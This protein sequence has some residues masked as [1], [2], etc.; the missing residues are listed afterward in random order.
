[1]NCKT[2]RVFIVSLLFAQQLSMARAQNPAVKPSRETRLIVDDGRYVED[3]FTRQVAVTND[4]NFVLVSDF[5]NGVRTFDASTGALVNS[6]E[7][8]SLPGDIRYDPTHQLFLTSGDVKIKIWDWQQQT[9]VKLVQQPVPSQFMKNLYVDTNKQYLFANNL[10]YSYATGK[11]VPAQ[12]TGNVSGRWNGPDPPPA[13]FSGDRYYIFD[14]RTG[15]VRIYNCLN[16]NL[17]RSYVLYHYKKGINNY[18]DHDSSYLFIS[19]LDGV[20]MISLSDGRSD[21]ASFDRTGAYD[22][23][24]E[25]SC[26]A[27]SFDGTYLV[28]GSNQGA[29][30]VILKKKDPKKGFAGNTAEVY[31]E[32]V[33]V[34]E[35]HAFHHSNKAVYTT[36]EAIH[37]LDLDEQSV[38]WDTEPK[39]ISARNI[40]FAP[41]GDQLYFAIGRDPKVN[42][43]WFERTY[44]EGKFSYNFNDYF[45]D[46]DANWGVFREDLCGKQLFAELVPLWEDRARVV[47]FR[48]HRPLA[49]SPASGE[50]PPT[51]IHGTSSTTNEP[52]Q[53]GSQPTMVYSPSR[54][55]SV[56]IKDFGQSALFKDGQRIGAVSSSDGV[57]Y[58]IEW[59]R[60][61]QYMAFGGSGRW[62]TVVNMG[63]GQPAQ[64]VYGESYI[65]T[66]AFSPDNKFLFTGSLKNEILMWRLSDG[67]LLRRLSGSNGGI[68]DTA[69]TPDGKILVSTAGDSSLRFWELPTGKLLISV[70]LLNSSALARELRRGIATVVDE[71]VATC[72]SPLDWVAVTPDGRFDSNNLE[73]TR[74]LHWLKSDAALRP[75]P[76]EIFTRDYYEPGL[77]EKVLN[78]T[79]LKPLRSLANLDTNIPLIE[80]TNV[81]E[82]KHSSSSDPDASDHGPSVAVTV[83]VQD[84]RSGSQQ[85]GGQNSGSYDLRLFRDGQLVG[86]WPAASANQLEESSLPADAA[87]QNWRN[88]HALKV[89]SSGKAVITFDN[90][91]LP[92]RKGV[93]SVQF[94]AYA[95]NS[96]RVKSLTTT[97]FIYTLP[98]PKAPRPLRRAYLVTMGV[99]ANQSHNLALELAVSSAERSRAVL[100]NKLNVDYQDVVEIPLYSDFAPDSNEVRIDT[101]RKADLHAVLDLLAGRT[102]DATIR[103][104]VDPKGQLRAA[105]PDDAVILYVASHGYADPEGT[106]YLLPSDT[107]ANW[108]ITEDVLTRCH[109]QPDE[110]AVCKHANDLL[111]H[112]VSSTELGAWWNGVDGGEMV[113]ILDSCHSGAVSGKEFRPG[114]LGDPG[115]GQSSYDKGMQIL[116]ASQPAQTAKGEWV[117][118]KGGGTIL[119]DALET[120][121]Q[122]KPND[123]LT[124]WLHDIEVQLP[125]TAKELYPELKEEDAQ[126]PV[127]LD[128]SRLK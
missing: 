77:L 38:E 79:P 41:D 11:L 95:F 75:L 6:L 53:V 67:K 85:T 110:S 91:R 8:H 31:R 98:P 88:T 78:G 7:G 86:E 49:F 120:V 115:F 27:I 45:N 103:K 18:I 59:S 121:A 109:S 29:G 114:P 87:L 63:T 104:E 68:T 83:T 100:K 56:A 44:S 13:T 122:Q 105:T 4:D 119:V 94:T 128:F 99:N 43:H 22:N 89:D 26:Y 62:V 125:A 72:N 107:G 127:L 23:V 118:G 5:Q 14:P 55:Y 73:Q 30:L 113:M 106:F 28:A 84:V 34:G 48:I 66:I 19:Y 10:K 112:S 92:Q 74:S 117:T 1:M 81:D 69:I 20:R 76:L 124:Q 35:L 116:S 65:T 32:P 52:V 9:L 126:I 42:R 111:S 2:A 108:G 70:F 46:L 24:N 17:I 80:I 96:D 54:H 21:Y 15:T 97:P 101:A 102:V 40:F 58:H 33:K 39:L 57:T 50:V 3:D 37:M 60:D 64:R 71:R 16:G 51:A 12:S 82:T 36:D 47:E 25:T 123:P 61:E 90:V 93:A